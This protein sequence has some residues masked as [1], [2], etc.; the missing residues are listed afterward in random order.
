MEWLKI[1]VNILELANYKCFYIYKWDTKKIFAIDYDDTVIKKNPTILI[2]SLPSPQFERK[3]NHLTFLVNNFELFKNRI[4]TLSNIYNIEILK[5]DVLPDVGHIIVQEFSAKEMINGKNK[6][7][8]VKLY[9]SRAT[10]LYK[11][12][13]KRNMRYYGIESFARYKSVIQCFS[14][15][16]KYEIFKEK[17]LILSSL[18]GLFRLEKTWDGKDF[19]LTFINNDY[20]AFLNTVLHV[21]F[22]C[23]NEDERIDYN[24]THY[25]NNNDRVTKLGKKKMSNNKEREKI[26]LLSLLKILDICHGLIIVMDENDALYLRE[27]ISFYDLIKFY[28]DWKLNVKMGKG[29]KVKEIP[30]ILNNTDE[31]PSLD[32]NFTVT[33]IAVSL[34]ENFFQTIIFAPINVPFP[35]KNNNDLTLKKKDYIPGGL[36]LQPTSGQYSKITSLDFQSL[37]PN[38]MATFGIIKGRVCRVSKDDFNRKKFCRYFHVLE[39]E[40][41]DIYFLSLKDE[42]KDFNPIRCFCQYLIEKRRQNP[43]VGVFKLLINSI[44]GLFAN[45]KFSLYSSTVATTITRYGRF[46]LTN[47]VEFFKNNFQL[48][49]LYGDTDSIFIPYLHYEPHYLALEYNKSYPQIQLKVETIFEK[50]ILIRKKLYFGK[51]VLEMDEEDEGVLDTGSGYKFSGFSKKFL[52]TYK[53]FL[54]GLINA[55]TEDDLDSKRKL[56]ATYFFE[57]CNNDENFYWKKFVE[58]L[59]L[60][61]KEERVKK[62]QSRGYQLINFDNEVMTLNHIKF[63]NEYIN[64]IIWKKRRMIKENDNIIFSRFNQNYDE[65]GTSYYLTLDDA[66][67]EK[68]F[69]NLQELEKFILLPLLGKDELSS[70]VL[71]VSIDNH[72]SLYDFFCFVYNKRKEK[73]RKKNIAFIL[74]YEVFD[75]NSK[76]FF[77]NNNF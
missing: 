23:N 56:F 40:D 1:N 3:Y 10:L 13:Q 2:I 58:P 69:K 8:V 4:S 22:V 64:E 16:L 71:Y 26:I 50:L 12:L 38:I 51:T 21:S 11:L 66:P 74:P 27:K 41:E 60:V 49:C 52:S 37:Y 47:A 32:T 39:I 33:T 5:M 28:P 48:E 24:I 14:N 54:C 36:V 42:E 73:K 65:E 67:P 18:R 61:L 62:F 63:S 19:S 43:T 30:I 53:K 75:P 57:N 15:Q 55:Q 20:T 70:L 72:F 17:G 46:F 34:L 68:R 35:S 9:C 76:F 44:Y 29:V 25:D 7:I 59:L 31:C 6:G 45:R 77:S